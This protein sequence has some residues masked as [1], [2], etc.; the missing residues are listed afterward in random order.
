MDPITSVLARFVRVTRG[1]SWPHREPPSNRSTEPPAM[2]QPA[3]AIADATSPSRYNLGILLVTANQPPCRGATLLR[4]TD[5]LHGWLDHGMNRTQKDRGLPVV[6]VG[7]PLIGRDEGHPASAELV[8]QETQSGRVTAETRWLV[9]E[10]YFPELS[11]RRDTKALIRWLMRSISWFLIE[12]VDAEAHRARRVRGPWWRRLKRSIPAWVGLTLAAPL[13]GVIWLILAGMLLV[14]VLH[15]PGLTK[16]AEGAATRFEQLV[17]ASYSQASS[18]TLFEA[19]VAGAERDLRWLAA[20]CPAIAVVAMSQGVPVAHELVRRCGDRV[21][22]FLVIG[23]ALRKLQVARRIERRT[24]PLNTVL[25]SAWGVA[26]AWLAVAASLLYIVLAFDLFVTESVGVAGFAFFLV[27]G[28]V[29]AGLFAW[30]GLAAGRSLHR[31]F[32]TIHT[33]IDDEL[34][35]PRSNVRWVEFVATADPIPNGPLFDRPRPDGPTSRIVA[36]RASVWQDHVTY[37]ENQEEVLPAIVTELACISQPEFNALDALRPSELE[38]R[39]RLWRLRWLVRMRP[40]VVP[41][42]VLGALV[43]LPGLTNPLSS[44]MRSQGFT[45]G[46]KVILGPFAILGALLSR[47]TVL[48]AITCVGLGLIAF[49]ILLALWGS[50]N[51]ATAS[52]RIDPATKP[53]N[54]T[55]PINLISVPTVALTEL[56]LLAFGPLRHWVEIVEDSNVLAFLEGEPVLAWEVVILLPLALLNFIL[57]RLPSVPVV[58]RTLAQR[59]L[60]LGDEAAVRWLMDQLADNRKLPPEYAKYRLGKVTWAVKADQEPQSQA[61]ISLRPSALTLLQN[62]AALFDVREAY[63][64]GTTY[65]KVSGRDLYLL[66]AL[67]QRTDTRVRLANRRDWQLFRKEL[68]GIEQ[69]LGLTS[70]GDVLAEVNDTSDR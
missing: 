4:V 30:G 24:V 8:V 63:W 17:G 39:E 2:R 64:D 57:R 36:N 47:A 28:T 67:G 54:V 16:L 45:E 52:G 15:I 69:C 22:L 70:G 29:Q 33:E 5:A 31:Q 35:L 12:Y 3:A 66:D 19:M 23:S 7:E 59:R 50:W 27:L 41:I 60:R 20:R 1:V 9:T 62:S 13:A 21:D 42:G 46:V 10:S 40:T 55:L 25:K 6:R 48:F 32:V 37:L 38:R 61:A 53:P 51:R 26:G 43:V 68:D 56:A 11:A 34:T 18:V 65:Y 14:Q 44:A 58:Q 49:Q